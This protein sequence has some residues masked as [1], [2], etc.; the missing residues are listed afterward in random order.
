MVIHSKYSVWKILVSTQNLV[1]DI[2][3]SFWAQENKILQEHINQ[4]A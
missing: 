1:V 2:L 3:T 4:N